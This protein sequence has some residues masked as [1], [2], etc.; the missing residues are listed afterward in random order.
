MARDN[1]TDA[2]P[3]RVRMLVVGLGLGL[4]LALG[5]WFFFG[6][7]PSSDRQAAPTPS[8]PASTPPSSGP[9]PS[10]AAT[11]SLYDSACGLKGGSTT[12]PT[13]APTDL[14]WENVKGWYLPVSVSA[15]PGRPDGAGAWT[16]F[17][18]TPTGAVLAAYSIP[19]R[20]AGVAPNYA[21]VLDRQTVPGVG[22]N[23][24]RGQGAPAISSASPV[25]P[26]GFVVDSYTDTDATVT[27]YLNNPST[28]PATCAVNVQWFGGAT[29]DWR[30][31]LESNGDSYSGCVQGAPSRYVSWGPTQ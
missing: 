13:S 3:S 14:T 15:G 16:C 1:D 17:A 9:S 4:L 8:V 25:I 19:I 18:H 27:L 31:R 28:G 24:L 30:V 23:A 2:S 29:G 10:A 11:D 7:G 26:R 12:V 20:L 21:D 22:Q 6:R 5:G